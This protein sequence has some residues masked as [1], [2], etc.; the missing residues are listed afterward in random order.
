MTRTRLAL[1]QKQYANDFIFLIHLSFKADGLV[2]G[3]RDTESLFFAGNTDRLGLGGLIWR[4][5]ESSS[6]GIIVVCA[7]AHETIDKAADGGIWRGTE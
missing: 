6:E 7:R 2:Y 1:T 5:T 3:L 4:G